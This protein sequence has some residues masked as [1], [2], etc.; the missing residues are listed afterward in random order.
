MSRETASILWS[1]LSRLMPAVRRAGSMPARY[2]SAAASTYAL[3]SSTTPR[4]TGPLLL[5]RW[6][7]FA[8]SY[9]VNSA[10]CSC[11]LMADV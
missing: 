6:T 7:Y 10:E 5:P 11:W 4:S 1:M 2:R 9:L 3:L 8:C